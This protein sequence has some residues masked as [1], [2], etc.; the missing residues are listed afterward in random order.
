MK[1]GDVD[2]LMKR[3]RD[4]MLEELVKLS[5]IATAQRVSLTSEERRDL[6]DE[7]RDRSTDSARSTGRDST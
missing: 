2:G 4:A 6:L 7:G 3:T 5:E 1:P